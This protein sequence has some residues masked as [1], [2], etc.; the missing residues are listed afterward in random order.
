MEDDVGLLIEDLTERMLNSLEVSNNEDSILASLATMEE[1]SPKLRDFL[2]RKGY[3]DASMRMIHVNETVTGFNRIIEISKKSNTR[4]R[5]AEERI[6]NLYSV[7]KELKH[8]KLLNFLYAFIFASIGF[9]VIYAMN[10]AAAGAILD[11]LRTIGYITHF[12]S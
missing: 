2:T 10:P 12:T 6:D 9:G 3:N 8:R 1:L 4:L 7:I 11:F 5:I